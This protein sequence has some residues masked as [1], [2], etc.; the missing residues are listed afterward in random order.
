MKSLIFAIFFLCTTISFSVK[1]LDEF[2]LKKHKT[3]FYVERNKNK[4]RVLYQIKQ[5]QV[6][7]VTQL[8]PLRPIWHDLEEGKHVYSHLSTFDKIAYG[9]SD[10]IKDGDSYKVKIKALEE[11]E[12][13]VQIQEG[14]DCKYKAIF[15]IKNHK[16][17]LNKIYVFAKETF[18]I[19]KVKYIKLYG[20]RVDNGKN[21]IE[22]IIP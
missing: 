2:E 19:P 20:K 11:R 7:R 3:L 10:Q 5:D 8:K 18:Y 13:K 14:S 1:S 22:K 12:F 21:I 9:I 16:A 17:Y 15:Q 6:C 4:N